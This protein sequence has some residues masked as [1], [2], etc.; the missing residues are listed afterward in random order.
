M[1][2]PSTLL[3]DVFRL[4]K[5]LHRFVSNS[6]SLCGWSIRLVNFVADTIQ[7]MFSL[8]NTQSWNPYF[9]QKGS[10][11]D[12]NSCSGVE[13][14]TLLSL[15]PIDRN[16][17]SQW[18]LYVDWPF[19][20]LIVASW[21]AYCKVTLG[22]LSSS[23]TWNSKWWQVHLLDWLIQTCFVINVIYSLV[24]YMAR[25][26]WLCCLDWQGIHDATWQCKL[27]NKVN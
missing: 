9:S 5:L 8:I 22:L 3:K 4:Y 20:C 10:T 14:S 6:S 18:N 16:S 1:N 7:L 17:S 12:T 24:S 2:P 23:V 11:S 25:P 26:E 15:P 21:L 13:E 19:I 27:F